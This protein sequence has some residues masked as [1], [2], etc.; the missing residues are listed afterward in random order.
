MEQKGNP[1]SRLSSLSALATTSSSAWRPAGTAAGSTTSITRTTTSSS[2]AT[3]ATATAT[4]SSAF[5]AARAPPSRAAGKPAGTTPSPTPPAAA[6]AP[7]F[8]PVVAR[9]ASAG[10]VS[11]ALHGAVSPARREEG[12]DQRKRQCNCRNSRCLKLYCECFAARQFC[13]GCNCLGCCNNLDN[14]LQVAKA[15]AATLERNPAAFMPKIMSSPVPPGRGPGEPAPGV[16]NKGCHC[17]KSNCLK[18]YCECFQANILCGD[19]CK[20]E[21][22]RNYEG[23]ADRRSVLQLAG[24][25]TPS[26]TPKYTSH[27][28]LSHLS[29]V[30]RLNAPYGRPSEQETRSRVSSS[31][32]K[33]ILSQLCQVMLLAAKDEV[34]RADKLSSFRPKSTLPLNAQARP[35]PSLAAAQANRPSSAPPADVIQRIKTPMRGSPGQGQG[36]AADSIDL[37]PTPV[38]FPKPPLRLPEYERAILEELSGFMRKTIQ[39]QGQRDADLGSQSQADPRLSQLAKMA[40]N[41]SADLPPP[42]SPSHSRDSKNNG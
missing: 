9:T 18:K 28:A 12:G 38:R 30:R 32:E 14:E 11:A 6:A 17:R 20:C 23:S 13:D 5:S 41:T 19:N 3:A 15:V 27:D 37:Q 4:T 10:G 16:H 42:A 1:E 24:R 33:P 2:T 39:H 25:C 34:A 8:R 7:S 31:M 29:H 36:C 26:P 22:C 21:D 35:V 40:A